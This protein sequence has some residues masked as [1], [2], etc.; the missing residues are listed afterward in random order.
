[1]VLTNNNLRRG[2]HRFPDA[3]TRQVGPTPEE[4]VF[5]GGE[6]L[7][8]SRGAPGLTAEPDECSKAAAE[9]EAALREPAASPRGPQGAVSAGGPSFL[10]EGASAPALSSLH[11]L[12][13]DPCSWTHAIR[14]AFRTP[15]LIT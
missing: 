11:L 8:R 4:H 12:L 10:P 6:Q 14:I 2:S 9:R 13:G 1:M 3:A 15:S 7:S 5:G